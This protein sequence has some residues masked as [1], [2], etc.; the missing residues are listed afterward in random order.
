[1]K[2]FFLFGPPGSGKG[3][4]RK[5]IQSYLDLKGKKWIDICLGDLLRSF[6]KNNVTPVKKELEKIINK[7]LL[8]PVAYS[9]FVSVERLMD[10]DKD[11]DYIIVDGGSRGVREAKL[12]FEALSVFDGLEALALILQV[13]DDEIKK[14][15][16]L[17]GREDDVDESIQSRINLFND[18]KRGTVAAIKYIEENN[19][20]FIHNIDGVGPIDD[21]FERIKKIIE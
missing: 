15:L 2:I 20:A 1:M 3:T 7:G 11:T 18:G 4:Q 13:P 12:F 21:V 10:A 17:R 9:L 19:L 6:V 14:R 16:L 5:K 8:V